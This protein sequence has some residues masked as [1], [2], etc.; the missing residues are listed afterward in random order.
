MNRI[1]TLLPVK[2]IESGFQ[3]KGVKK[4]AD[5]IARREGV[6]KK[7]GTLKKKTRRMFVDLLL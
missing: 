7:R 6:E 2:A 3:R 1:P 5:G 4:E